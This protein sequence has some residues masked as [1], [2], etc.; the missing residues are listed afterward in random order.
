MGLNDSTICCHHIL[1][2]NMA[3][4]MG[5]D[6]CAILEILKDLCEQSLEEF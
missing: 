1:M 4:I 5:T 2:A 3:H 6:G